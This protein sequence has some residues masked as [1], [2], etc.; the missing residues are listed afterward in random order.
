MIVSSHS[1]VVPS[2]LRR[3]RS[4]DLVT[5]IRVDDIQRPHKQSSGHRLRQT[6]LCKKYEGETK[7][8]AQR[9]LVW[10]AGTEDDRCRSQREPHTSFRRVQDDDDVMIGA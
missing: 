6:A 9:V 10:L 4:A 3:E 8:L 5:R 2:N 7:H 1:W